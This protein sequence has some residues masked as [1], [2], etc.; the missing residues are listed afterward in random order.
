MHRVLISLA[1]NDEQEKHL[2]EARQAL[3]QVLHAP[4]YTPAIWTEPV[5]KQPNSQP[6][7]S[8]NPS[9]GRG[10]WSAASPPPFGGG[11]GEAGGL[12]VCLYLNQLVEADTDLD[13]SQLV[14]QLKQLELSLGRTPEMRSQGLVPID[15]DLLQHDDQRYHLRDWQRPY[16]QQ[17]LQ[18]CMFKNDK[19]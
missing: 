3:A 2:S 4:V 18:H 7:A 1:S 15:L 17:L 8:P 11:R 10:L 5:T 6:P 12:A 16:V 19:L 14:Q 13:A 9:K